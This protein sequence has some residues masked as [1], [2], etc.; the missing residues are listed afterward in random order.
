MEWIS[1]KDRLPELG[2]DMRTDDLLV[3]I[4]STSIHAYGEHLTTIGWFNGIKWRTIMEEQGNTFKK[5]THWMPL[6][7]K[8]IEITNK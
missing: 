6:P 1:V 5:V 8:P 7:P 2:E 4:I 3:S